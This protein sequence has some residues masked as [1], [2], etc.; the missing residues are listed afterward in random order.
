MTNE[1]MWPPVCYRW[2][3]DDDLRGVYDSLFYLVYFCSATKIY[4][5]PDVVLGG[6]PPI[7]FYDE[8]EKTRIY[9][10]YVEPILQAAFSPYKE[11]PWEIDDRLPLLWDEIVEFYTNLVW[12]SK[13]RIPF[14]F[15]IDRLRTNLTRI[16]NDLV[17]KSALRDPSILNDLL[18][19]LYLYQKGDVSVILPS[20]DSPIN[21]V[22]LA[23]KLRRSVRFQ[24]L[25]RE[26]HRLGFL[27][28]K[29]LGSHL[30]RIGHKVNQ[31]AR[32]RPFSAL[33]E[34]GKASLSLLLGQAGS[35]GSRAATRI[36]EIVTS[37]PYTPPVFDLVSIERGFDSVFYPHRLEDENR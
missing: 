10:K 17:I 15:D 2:R 24:E 31:I 4:V 9:R 29:Q 7:S 22:E 25:S 14:V 30:R 5:T 35:L 33:L 26:T 11:E 1:V 13:L 18:A 20:A 16:R 23:L 3:I 21:P 32:S 27:D 34:T 19:I 36:A 37:K 28:S 6:K 12:C 8:R